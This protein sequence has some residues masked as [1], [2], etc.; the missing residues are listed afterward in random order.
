[1][2]YKYSMDE[3]LSVAKRSSSD[4][5]KYLHSI[6]STISVTNVEDEPSYQEKDI[7]LLWVY[8]D[9]HGNEHEI[10]IEIKGDRWENTGNYFFET[11]SNKSKGTP[12]CFMYTEAIYVYYYFV[13]IKELHRIPVEKARRW[14]LDNIDKFKES[15]TSTPVGNGEKYI[16]VGRLV[17]KKMIQEAIP[18]IRVKSLKELI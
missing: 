3:A 6:K 10:T 12:G 18:E 15:E 2:T 9:D 7:D 1:M 11:I 8:K 5:E 17:P 13:N 16:T 4:I 14:F